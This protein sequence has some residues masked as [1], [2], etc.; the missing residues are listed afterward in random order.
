MKFKSVPN[1]VVQKRVRKLGKWRIVVWFKFDSDGY[2]T[3]DES[4]ITPEDLVKLKAKFKVVEEELTYKELQAKYKEKTGES[5]VGKKKSD[6][7][8]ELEG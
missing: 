5:P 6:L 4:K 7:I 2:A 1:R 8:K 3:I